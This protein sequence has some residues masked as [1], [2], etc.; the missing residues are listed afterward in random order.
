MSVPS[1]EE[2]SFEQGISKLPLR[3]IIADWSLRGRVIYGRFIGFDNLRKKMWLNDEPPARL[4]DL[5]CR[6]SDTVVESNKYHYIL[7]GPE[8]VR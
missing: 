2:W 3:G 6:L 5:V 8:K 1:F 7:Q 4:G